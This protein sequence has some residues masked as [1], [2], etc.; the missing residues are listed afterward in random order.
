VARIAPKANDPDLALRAL[1][2]NQ[3]YAAEKKR[4]S[5]ILPSFTR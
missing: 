3:P 4:S 5:A 1:L 2:S